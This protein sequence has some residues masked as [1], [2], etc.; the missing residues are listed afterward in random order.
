MPSSSSFDSFSSFVTPPFSED[1][2]PANHSNQETTGQR[3]S[4]FSTGSKSNNSGS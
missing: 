2:K 3:V 4:S 1:L